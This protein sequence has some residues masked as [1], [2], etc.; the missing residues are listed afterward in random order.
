VLKSSIRK[1]NIF[2]D[3]ENMNTTISQFTQ[4][5]GVDVLLAFVEHASDKDVDRLLTLVQDVSKHNPT[6]QKQI[7]AIRKAWQE[8]FPTT[9]LIKRALKE[10]N[11]QVK[12]KLISNVVLNNSYGPA[13]A[14]RDRLI[15]Q[16]NFRPPFVTMM[17]P[18]MR[19]NLKCTGCYAG[20]YTKKD[21]L[22]IEVVDRIL[23]E[24]KEMGIY[25]SVILGGEPFVREDMFNMFERHSDVEFIVFT[26]GT[27]LNDSTVKRIAKL[28]NIAPM[29]SIEGFKEDTDARRGAG[30]YDKI[31]SA[32][33]RLHDAGV[34]FGFSTMVTRHNVETI[35]GDEYN[36]MLMEKGA[37]IGWHFLYMPIGREPDPNM[38][39]TAEQREYMRTQGAAR[40]RATMPLFVMDFWNDAPYVGG[41]I[42]GGKEYFHIN[43][44][45]D[46]EPCIFTHFA[47]DNIMEKS[48]REVLESPYFRAIRA[49]QPFNKNLLLPC[50]LIDNPDG[51]RSLYARYQPRPTHPGAESMV[52]ELVPVLDAYSASVQKM[53]ASGWQK[54]FVDKGFKFQSVS[55]NE[56][57][58]ENDV[59]KIPA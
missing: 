1:I 10:L 59:Q 2:D 7:P 42:A 45:G 24:G 39:P 20:E 37:Y 40:I 27:M 11:P 19:C 4:D 6:A 3:E 5:R 18:S 9:R 35:C 32:M 17:S 44:K 47:V 50:Q 14:T 28:G 46:V 54:D 29:I 58:P 8:D 13:T 33:D 31:L 41:C 34:L 43:S 51:F 52:N 53:M 55:V 30:T 23:R 21:D 16:E 36:R 57:E 26:N 48:L 22:P 12:R 38:M 56:K 49:R 25:L 15:K